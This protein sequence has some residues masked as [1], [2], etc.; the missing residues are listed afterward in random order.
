M[1]A[2]CTM[3][4]PCATVCTLLYY[5]ATLLI[6]KQSGAHRGAHVRLDQV[7]FQCRHLSDASH[8]LCVVAQ[9]VLRQALAHD[10]RAAQLLQ[11]V[12]SLSKHSFTSG[13]GMLKQSMSS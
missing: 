11:S 13:M 8:E 9:H 1:M 10:L 3:C 5:F 6:V 2:A 4:Q 7:C 12:R